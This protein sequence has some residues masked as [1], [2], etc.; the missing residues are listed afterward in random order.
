MN[1]VT[2]IA[3]MLLSPD[4]QH[5]FQ[6]SLE[7][8]ERRDGIT[9]YQIRFVE[10]S[11]PSLIRD[12]R[13]NADTE[14][15]GLA[16]I[17]DDGQVTDTDLRVSISTRTTARIRVRYQRNANVNLLVPVSMEEDYRNDN[18]PGLGVGLITCTATYSNYRRFRAFGRIL[19]P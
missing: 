4:L 12:D 11:R 8:T 15:S 18:G 5:R 1:P 3:L 16:Q 17:V 9:T 10:K 14:L 6:F 2:A 13:D 19:P 7:G